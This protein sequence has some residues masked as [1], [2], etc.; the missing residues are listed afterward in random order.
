MKTLMFLALTALSGCTDAVITNNDNDASYIDASTDDT[1][2]TGGKSGTGGNASTGGNSTTGGTSS[3]ST[4][5]VIDGITV[6]SDMSGYT[7][8]C[9]DASQRTISCMPTLSGVNPSSYLYCTT[10]LSRDCNSNTA[11]IYEC[12]SC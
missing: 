5:T 9:F 2:S 7:Y 3:A 10:M 4:T 6:H 1:M 12:Y 8:T 11:A